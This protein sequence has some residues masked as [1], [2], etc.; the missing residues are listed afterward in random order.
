MLIEETLNKL[1]EE[2]LFHFKFETDGDC[3]FHNEDNF[4]SES[5]ETYSASKIFKKNTLEADFKQF[6]IE[7]SNKISRGKHSVYFKEYFLEASEKVS[8]LIEELAEYSSLTLMDSNQFL[9]LTFIDASTIEKN[10][11]EKLDL[12]KKDI[13][14]NKE[15]LSEFIKENFSDLLKE[16]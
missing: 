7:I 1:P 6:F 16:L 10:K 5:F 11:V 4:F 8:E 9:S 12:L 2:I 3:Y 14:E 13:L 15:E